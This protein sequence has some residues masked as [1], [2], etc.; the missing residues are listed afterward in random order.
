MYAVAVFV[1]RST[2]EICSPTA[3]KELRVVA[4]LPR[5]F[6]VQS[7]VAAALIYSTAD[8]ETSMFTMPDAPVK[9]ISTTSFGEVSVG[10][11]DNAT[12]GTGPDGLVMVIPVPAVRP[13]TSPVPKDCHAAPS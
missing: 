13:V 1:L 2:T 4:P 6:V 9:E 11:L 12:V 5:T 8:V 10:L 3:I 7:A